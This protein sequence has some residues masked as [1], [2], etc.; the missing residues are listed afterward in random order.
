MREVYFVGKP[1]SGKTSLFN[2]LTGLNQKVGNYAG[3]TVEIKSGKYKD[4]RIVD[5]PGLQSLDTTSPEEK[6]SKQQILKLKSDDSLIVFVVNGTR[7]KDGFLLFSQIADLQ[8]PIVLVVNFKDELERNNIQIDKEK[9]QERLACPVVI[10][11]SKKGQGIEELHSILDNNE[12]TIPNTFCLSQ[13]D[14]FEKEDYDNSYK[15]L[16]SSDREL[17]FWEEDYNARMKVINSIAIDCVDTTNLS[18]PLNAAQK[19]DKILLHPVWGLIAFV[20]ILFLLFQAVFSL[21][22]YPM[23][24]IDAGIASLADLCK[25][26]IGIPWLSELLGDAIIPGI[27][28]VVIFIPQIAILFFLLGLLE[29][30]GY[31]SRISFISDAFLRKFGLSGHSVVPLMSSWACSIPAIMSTRIIADPKERLTVI[32]ASPLM[33]CSAR[34]PVYTILIAI[35]FPNSSTSFW[36]AQGLA[37]LSLYLLGVIATLVVSLIVNRNLKVDSK[38]FWVLELPVF[39]MP[40][41]NNIFINVYQKTKSFVVQAGKI[42]LGISIILWILATNSPHNETYINEQFQTAQEAT[43]SNFTHSKES[44]ELE[45]SYLG[46][47]G[48]VIEPTIRPL[49]YDWKIGIALLSSFAAREVFVGTLAP[50]YSIGSEEESSIIARLQQE[51]NPVTGKPRFNLATSVSLLLFYVFAMQCMST[52]AIVRKETGSWKFVIFQFVFMLI[53]A[54]GFALLGY[55][56]LK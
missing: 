6:I 32:L 27:G 30:T 28:G 35:I 29:Q 34:L 20:I 37:L 7:L 31:L 18:N 48:K 47:M 55:Q 26:S 25:T 22:S 51:K 3:V 40:N 56:L 38:P 11:N 39:R 44:I 16:V 15:Q 17:S 41:W 43:P 49:G 36:G 23:D 21:S 33:T 10:M 4:Q 42:I 12:G 9:L 1:N 50:I 52:L 46:Y 13:Y 54:Y 2:K 8:I 24:W 14:H 5:L 53:L 45:Y 19:W